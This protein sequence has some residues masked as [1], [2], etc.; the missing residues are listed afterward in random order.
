MKAV[1]KAFADIS[2]NSNLKN[3]LSSRC[4]SVYKT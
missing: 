3:G 2:T 4:G 1:I